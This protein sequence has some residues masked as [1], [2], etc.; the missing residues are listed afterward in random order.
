MKEWFNGD[1]F[2]M[3]SSEQGF[4]VKIGTGTASIQMQAKDEGFDEIEDMAFT[5]TGTGVLML[6]D[7]EIK[8]VLT[9]DAR[10]F[11]SLINNR[12]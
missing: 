2:T 10:F 12:R 7:S 5:A 1:V 4:K 6:P 11:L 8:I 3:G 9:G